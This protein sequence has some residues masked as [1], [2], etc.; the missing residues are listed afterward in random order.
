[1]KPILAIVILSLLLALSVGLWI[2]SYAEHKAEVKAVDARCKERI[3]AIVNTADSAI[4]AERSIVA[5]L[6]REALENA[7]QGDG[8]VA[9]SEKRQ[10]LYEEQRRTIPSK[11]DTALKDLILWKR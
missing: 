10:R 11:S 8:H 7:A 2:H 6:R 1:M 3:E 9:D 4:C 5:E